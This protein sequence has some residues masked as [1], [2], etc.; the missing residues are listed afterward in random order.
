MTKIIERTIFVDFVKNNME[1]DKV[2]DHCHLRGKYRAPAHSK[3]NINVT[4]Y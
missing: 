2:R 4:H 3:F 1:S